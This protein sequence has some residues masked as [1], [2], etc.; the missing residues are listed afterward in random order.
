MIFYINTLVF[1]NFKLCKNLVEQ[2]ALVLGQTCTVL[3]LRPIRS[4]SLERHHICSPL[5]CIDQTQYHISC[6][7]CNTGHESLNQEIGS[8]GKGYKQFFYPKRPSWCYAPTLG[9]NKQK[10]SLNCLTGEQVP[11]G[12][13][14][15]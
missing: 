3:P 2:I 1:L 6:N 13:L 4:R 14:L 7:L 15:S 8:M 10:T 5:L 9:E 12:P 11:Q